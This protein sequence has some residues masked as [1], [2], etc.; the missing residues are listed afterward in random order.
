MAKKPFGFEVLYDL[1]EDGQWKEQAVGK[2]HVAEDVDDA[3]RQ[4]TALAAGLRLR[5]RMVR[6]I[7]EQGGVL[8]ETILD[9]KEN[10]D[11]T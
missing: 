1:F 5:R 7:S 11:P 6:V 2:A 4:G 8:Q 9:F 3:L 10:P